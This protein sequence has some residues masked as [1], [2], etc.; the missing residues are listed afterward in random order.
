[1]KG[2]KKEGKEKKRRD[3]ER[4]KSGP[5]K[6]AER[7]GE[8]RPNTKG[9]GGEAGKESRCQIRFLRL[10]WGLRAEGKS[11]EKGGTRR[12]GVKRR[13]EEREKRGKAEEWSGSSNP[14]YALGEVPR[15]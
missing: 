8:E 3:F 13:E 1:M 15:G 5:P 7:R 10:A 6:G 11:N 9:K 12:E 4:E 14:G 2:G